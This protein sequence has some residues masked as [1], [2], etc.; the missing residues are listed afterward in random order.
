MINFDSYLEP[1]DPEEV[2]TDECDCGGLDPDCDE[3]G[4]KGEIELEECDDCGYIR[5]A[6]DA[7]YDSWKEREWE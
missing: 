2:I 4:G 6:C 5:C 3:C 1:P 7:M